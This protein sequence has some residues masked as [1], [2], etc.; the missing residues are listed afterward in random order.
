MKKC[1]LLLIPVLV[2]AACQKKSSSNQHCYYCS[3]ND[4][5]VSTIP[6]LNIAHTKDTTGMYCDLNPAQEQFMILEKTR[7]DTGFLRNDT[8]SRDYWTMTCQLY[9]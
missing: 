2:I 3:I 7:M 9:N 4:S 8:F 6:A 5:V 1:L